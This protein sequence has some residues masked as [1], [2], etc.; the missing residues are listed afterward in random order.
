MMLDALEQMRILNPTLTLI[1]VLPTFYDARLSY[2]AMALEALEHDGV[3]VLDVRIGRSVRVAEAAATGTSVA[4][5]A[6]GNPQTDNYRL[7]AKVVMK[8]Q[9]S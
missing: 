4:G 5:Y 1:G 7:L 9:K 8:W 3:P 6:P 2:H